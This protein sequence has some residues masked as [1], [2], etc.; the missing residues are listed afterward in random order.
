MTHRHEPGSPE[1]MEL[2][3]R[4]SDYLDD[5]LPQD[6]C[7]QL[8]EHLED[9]PQCVAFLESLR[10]TVALVR[11]DPRPEVPEELRRRIVDAWHRSRKDPDA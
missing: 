4:L 7:R 11:S 1:C 2:L 5:D 3:G 10:R 6:A 8:E 9:C